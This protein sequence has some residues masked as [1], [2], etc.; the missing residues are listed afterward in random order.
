MVKL[1]RNRTGKQEGL[2]ID[3]G[4]RNWSKYRAG[5]LRGG[6]PSK[7]ISPDH[8]AYTPLTS[9]SSVDLPEPVGPT[10]AH[11]LSGFNGQAEFVNQGFAIWLIAKGDLAAAQSVRPAAAARPALQSFLLR[12]FAFLQ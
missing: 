2:L 11:A 10:T 9:I 6:T 4:D 5:S 1:S 3:D 12:V 8:G 7:R